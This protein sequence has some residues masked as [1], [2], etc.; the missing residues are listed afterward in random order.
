M[1]RISF[2]PILVLACASTYGQIQQVN[3][4]R[5]DEL[6]FY[7]GTNSIEYDDESEG[8]PYLSEAFIPANINGLKE[9]QFVRFNAV[10]SII[11]LKD[12]DD[13]LTLSNSYDYIIELLD[14]SEKMYETHVF[15]NEDR[16]TGSSFFE[17]LH[18]SEKYTLFL[19]ERIIYTPPKKAKSSY[20]QDVPGKF[21]KGRALFYLTDLNLTNDSLMEVPRKKKNFLSLFKGKRKSVEKFMKMEKL[22]PEKKEDIIRI[23]NFYFRQ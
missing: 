11:E 18:S 19:K 4:G 1:K 15:I 13:V 23:L 22:K 7:V 17:K 21:K 9:T 10:E 2:I 12:M 20:E 8:S 5:L 14:G 16:T 6:V 3:N